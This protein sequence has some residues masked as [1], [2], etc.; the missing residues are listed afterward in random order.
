MANR[1]KEVWITEK[2]FLLV[3]L[4]GYKNVRV[5]EEIVPNDEARNILGENVASLGENVASK[6]QRKGKENKRESESACMSD[7][8]QWQIWKTELLADEDW[9]ASAVRQSG[10]GIG[11]IT[12]L[13]VYAT[14]TESRI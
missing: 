11:F 6:Q 12:Q 4:S 5:W 7:R 10:Q 3:D 2:D 1:R 9:R 13:P 14:L 8:E